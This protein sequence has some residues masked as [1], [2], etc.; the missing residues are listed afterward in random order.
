WLPMIPDTD[1]RNVATQAAEP[2]SVLNAYRRL[3]AVRRGSPAL[4][5]GSF[6][7]VASGDRDVLAY[8]READGERALIAINFATRPRRCRLPG[9]AWRRLF[10][11][12]AT[13]ELGSAEP[14]PDR[15]RP[16]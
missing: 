2:G 1:R 12:D 11:T 4:H 9:G 13:G 3:L 14:A 8:A 5:G 7:R 10:D 6:A 16:V 15:G